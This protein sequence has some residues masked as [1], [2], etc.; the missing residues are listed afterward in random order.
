MRQWRSNKTRT[1]SKDK[2]KVGDI[3]EKEDRCSAEENMNKK[4]E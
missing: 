3:C 1:V 2:N 4:K